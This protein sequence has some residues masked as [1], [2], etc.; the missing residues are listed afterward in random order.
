MSVW[1]I[2]HLKKL[3]KRERKKLNVFFFQCDPDPRW[4]EHRIRIRTDPKRWNTRFQ[5]KKTSSLL[6]FCDQVITSG[7]QLTPWVFPLLVSAPSSCRTGELIL[8][9]TCLR[10]LMSFLRWS[11]KSGWTCS[12][13]AFI[14]ARKVTGSTWSKVSNIPASKQNWSS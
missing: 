14:G 8:Y 12:Q 6:I 4:E 5:G 13:A 3:E 2:L 9:G 10:S 1:C 11:T 7:S